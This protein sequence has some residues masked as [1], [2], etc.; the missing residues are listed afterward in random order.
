MPLKQI[1]TKE[2][3]KTFSTSS[4]PGGQNVNKLATK[5]TI[6]WC[7]NESSILNQYQK[8]KVKRFPAFKKLINLKGEIVISESRSRSQKHNLR[9]AIAKLNKLVN[10][11]IKPTKTRIL[12]TPTKN[13]L[14]R[15]KKLKQHRK[16]KK[17]L[18]KTTKGQLL[19]D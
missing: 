3:V 12:T 4:G 9:L 2:L 18:R 14:E 19:M 15:R 11:A 6:R 5:A 13:S 16:Q 8:S 10:Q 7:Y 1:P 17:E